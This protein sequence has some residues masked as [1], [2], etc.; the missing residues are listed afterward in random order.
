MHK[1]TDI[2]TEF[3][4]RPSEQLSIY[5][6]A[7]LSS[8][9]KFPPGRCL[10]H[11]WKNAKYVCMF[12]KRFFFILSGFFFHV[13]V[14]WTSWQQSAPKHTD[15][16]PGCLRPGKERRR[17]RILIV[18]VHS[19]HFYACASLEGGLHMHFILTKV[20]TWPGNCEWN[21]IRREMQ[22]FFFFFSVHCSCVTW[23]RDG[24]KALFSSFFCIWICCMKPLESH[25]ET[26]L[27]LNPTLWG[28]GNTKTLCI[29]LNR[30]FSNA[31][32]TTKK[33]RMSAKG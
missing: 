5:N 23:E 20:K 26:Q 22:F 32:D 25:H 8:S 29:S 9:S 6:R 18:L 30:V 2:S 13:S 33:C 11:P 27:F 19:I 14:S 10:N 4:L 31:N 1:I 3:L 17:P 7:R 24:E 12:K 28:K 15:R 16:L 21:S